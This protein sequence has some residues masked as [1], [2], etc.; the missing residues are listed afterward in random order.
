M[1]VAAGQSAHKGTVV[2]PQLMRAMMAARECHR[3]EKRTVWG[4]QLPDGG[5]GSSRELQTTIWTN[6]HGLCQTNSADTFRAK[7]IPP[8]QEVWIPVSC[9][10][11]NAGANDYNIAVHRR[12]DRVV[13]RQT[14]IRN[15]NRSG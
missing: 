9:P 8:C 12:A 15:M 2:D 11:I 5:W 13:N 7:E 3:L 4:S 6:I 14:I 10:G 1:P